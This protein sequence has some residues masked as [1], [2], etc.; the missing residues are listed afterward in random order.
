MDLMDTIKKVRGRD[1]KDDVFW[2]NEIQANW[3]V[4]KFLINVAII[5]IIM[6]LLFKFGVLELEFDDVLVVNAVEAPVLLISAFLCWHYKGEKVWLK[7]LMC[8]ATVFAVMGMNAV[9]NTYTEILIPFPIVLSCRYYNKRLTR[10]MAV[11]TYLGLAVSDYLFAYRNETVYSEYKTM[12]HYGDSVI[13]K[14]FL[15]LSIT[16]ACVEL[17]SAVM[18]MV[19]NQKEITKK[20]TRTEMELNTAATIQTNMIPRDFSMFANRKEFDVYA[21]MTPAK[22]I[23]GDF[24]DT[25]MIDDKHLLLVIA[26]VSDKGIPAALF[27]MVTKILIYDLA[28]QGFSPSEILYEANNRLCYN[29]EAEMFVTVW[30]GIFNTETGKMIASNAGHEYPIV[31]RA[32]GKYELIKDKHGLVLAGMEDSEYENY[33]FDLSKGDSIFVY[34]DGVSEANNID[35]ELFG[36]D[37]L[38]DALNSNPDRRPEQVIKDMKNSIDSF[39]GEADQFDDIT[40]L[41]FLVEKEYKQGTIEKSFETAANDKT[42]LDVTE[43]VES[44]LT[45]SL[46]ESE[47]M[48][49]SQFNIV[50]DELCSNITQYSDATKVWVKLNIADDV[51]GLEIKDDGAMYNLLEAPEPTEESLEDDSVGGY[52]IFMVKKMMDTVD[53]QYLEGKNTV[54]LTKKR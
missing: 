39:A 47:S 17:S 51:I 35:G 44:N 18:N 33:E 23:G 43:F 54:T 52:G 48:L 40:M 30:L 37:R 41:S 27:M 13:S 36:F 3:F 32:G 49:V 4:A 16:I 8:F 42:A 34:T 20:N 26:D 53:Y 46:D 11:I 21:S 19:L 15:M 45:S 7:Y 2:E 1:I 12:N 50:I 5:L 9:L 38:L 24:Y 10:K 31:R 25:Y 6:E 29:N 14:A 22:A 28:V